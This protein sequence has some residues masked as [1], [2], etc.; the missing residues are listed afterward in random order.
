MQYG[1]TDVLIFGSSTELGLLYTCFR[2]LG[3][4]T[5]WAKNQNDSGQVGRYIARCHVKWAVGRSGGQCCSR[6]LVAV[7][8]KESLTGDTPW[9]SPCSHAYSNLV[10]DCGH[11][12]IFS[13]CYL[14][15]SDLFFPSPLF[16]YPFR[17]Y[18]SHQPT[19]PTEV[20]S[21]LL[22]VA[23]P[24]TAEPGGLP[25]MGSHSRTWLK[26]LS[27]SHIWIALTKPWFS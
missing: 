22:L 23:S 20:L 26:W 11:C 7:T 18:Q 15:K 6:P 3:T 5:V 1:Y 8:A 21:A 12:H 16:S 24:G 13:W 27:S 14:G 9:K 10:E 17:H 19:P 25:S 4:Q 2:N